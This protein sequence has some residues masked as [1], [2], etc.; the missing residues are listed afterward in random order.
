MRAMGN[1]H[2]LILEDG[3]EKAR[4]A[5]ILGGNATE[6]L[7]IE[8]AFQVMTAEDDRIGI[9]HAGFAM[10]AL[11][12]KKT[13]EA[14]WHR[15]GGSVTLLVESGLDSSKRLVGIPYGSIAR[16]ILLYLQTQAVR[17]RSRDVELGASMNAWLGAMGITVGGKGEIHV[18]FRLAHCA[19]RSVSY[20][21]C[22]DL[23][24]QAF[25]RSICGRTCCPTFDW[26]A[27]LLAIGWRNDGAGSDDPRQQGWHR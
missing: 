6:R 3:I 24:G 4:Q 10:A 20:W 27:S 22:L 1:V 18:P 12:H 14:V 21:H 19:G 25:S 26:T 16:M 7:C 15:E 8:A 9:A 13:T 23:F 17:T 2:R 5:A 11:P